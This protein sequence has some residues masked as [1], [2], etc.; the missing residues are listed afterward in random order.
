MAVTTASCQSNVVKCD[1]GGEINNKQWI[2]G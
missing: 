2:V 1:D